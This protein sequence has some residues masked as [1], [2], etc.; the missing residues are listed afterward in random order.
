[1]RSQVIHFGDAVIFSQFA[2][3]GPPMGQYLKENCPNAKRPM[4]YVIELPD[5]N[6]I[7]RT[8][9]AKSRY[10]LVVRTVG[11]TE[12]SPDLKKAFERFT[13]WLITSDVTEMKIVRK[14]KR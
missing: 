3:I 7:V 13:R 1:M 6:F 2:V 12:I 9:D 5:S 14:A 4:E 8:W 10:L 11:T